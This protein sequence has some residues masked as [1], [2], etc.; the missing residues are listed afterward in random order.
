MLRILMTALIVSAGALPAVTTGADAGTDA[1][2]KLEQTALRSAKSDHLDALVTP[3]AAGSAKGVRYDRG[4]LDGQPR[5]KG[6][7]EWECLA[8]ALYF[9]ARGETV[10]GQFAVAE[11]ILNRVDSGRFPDS[12][13]GVIHQGT[14]KRYGCQFTYTCDGHP[15]KISEPTAW[16]RVGKVAKAMISGVAPRNLTKGATHYHTKAVRPA[17][18]RVYDHTATIG[19]HKFY[20]HTWRVSEN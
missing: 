20:R 13:C 19:T 5:A 10:K 17:W 6:G 7:A 1:L 12:V 11:V 18:S 16:A 9:E 14:G 2:L 15:E 4:W 3:A 8:E